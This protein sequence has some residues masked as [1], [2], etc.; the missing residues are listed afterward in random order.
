MNR[1]EYKQSQKEG[2]LFFK[3]LKLNK[4][5]TIII[6]VDHIVLIGNDLTNMKKLKRQLIKKF[7]IDLGKLNILP[8][9]IFD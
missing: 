9:C 8:R 7:K 4:I 2:T 5:M 3:H 6:Y 1:M